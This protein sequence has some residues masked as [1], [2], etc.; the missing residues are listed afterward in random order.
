MRRISIAD[1]GQV[2]EKYSPFPSGFEG[3]DYQNLL[4]GKFIKTLADFQ[5]IDT[6]RCL[7]CGD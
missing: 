7:S 3:I 6:G 4:D 5:Q 1:T 2:F